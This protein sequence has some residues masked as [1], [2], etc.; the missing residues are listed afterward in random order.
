MYRIL[1]VDDERPIVDSVSQVLSDHTPFELDI[2]RAYTFIEALKWADRAR[3]DIVLSDIRMPGMNGV[4]LQR[5]IMRRWPRCRFIFLTAFDDL[6]YAQQAIANGRVTAYLTKNVDNEQIVQIVQ[7]A[8]DETDKEI[9]EADLLYRTQGLMQQMLPLL[10][11]EFFLKLLRQEGEPVGDRQRAAKF[12]ELQIGLDPQMPV[13]LLLCRIDDWGDIASIE[14]KTLLLYAIQNILE[15]YMRPNTELA[16]LV[17]DPGRLVCFIQLKPLVSRHYVYGTLESVQVSCKS[18]LRLPLSL[19]LSDKAIAWQQAAADFYRMKQTLRF[20]Y[21]GEK[22][23]LLELREGWPEAERDAAGHGEPTAANLKS[24][25]EELGALLE[26]GQ[27][28]AFFKLFRE[29]TEESAPKKHGEALELYHALA[30]LFVSY[31]NRRGLFAE[32]EQ[33]LNLRRLS[34]MGEEEAWPESL[35]VFRRLAEHIFDSRETQQTERTQRLIH[36]VQHFVKSHLHEDLS[37]TRISALINHSPSYF[38]RVYKRVTGTDLSEYILHQRMAAAKE[39]LLHTHLKI[40]EIAAKV[41]Y[42]S[43]TQF[44]KMFKKSFLLTPQ[45]FRDANA[46]TFK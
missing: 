18:L 37:L 44:S 20:E 17:Y 46:Q 32:T 4:E 45:E 40:Y 39:M 3:L 38:S 34:A 6:T 33:K 35:L 28:E 8:I 25:V 21:G 23:L 24:G 16:T 31:L 1:I 29:L 26:S 13:F 5:E 7:K 36:D 14:D 41:G 10:R 15:E 30:A 43:V 19:M 42:E 2:C 12:A 11:R 22:E 27:K 9:R